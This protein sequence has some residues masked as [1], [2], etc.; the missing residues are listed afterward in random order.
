M[1]AQRLASESRFT[2]AT[3]PFLK[4][5]P[6][7]DTVIDYDRYK[8]ERLTS[9]SS[10]CKRASHLHNLPCYFS[11]KALSCCI[12]T[13]KAIFPPCLIRLPSHCGNK[14]IPRF[15]NQKPPYLCASKYNY[16]MTIAQVDINSKHFIPS[17]T[18]SPRF[19]SSTN[20]A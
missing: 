14:L 10:C 20:S 5:K 12:S 13:A 19:Y 16:T 8:Y 11:S 7:M 2:V 6:N 17:D 3:H 18:Q 1:L 4:L 9:F 15:Q